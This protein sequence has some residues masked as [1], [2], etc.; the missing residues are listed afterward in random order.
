M[1]SSPEASVPKGSVA[2][3]DRTVSMTSS[4]DLSG[5]LVAE[6]ESD[7]IFFFGVENIDLVVNEDLESSLVAV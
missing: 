6:A 3:S 1:A 7:E 4:E 5:S 2:K